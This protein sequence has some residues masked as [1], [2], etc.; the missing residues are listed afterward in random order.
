MESK[1]SILGYFFALAA[2]AIWSG[3]FILARDLNE[4]IS[5]INLAFLRWVI[6]IIVFLPFAYKHLISDGKL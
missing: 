4:S 6:A 5:P 3:N 2:T 1:N